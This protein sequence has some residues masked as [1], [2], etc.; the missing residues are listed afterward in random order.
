LNIVLD[1]P[2]NMRMFCESFGNKAK[3]TWNCVV[4]DTTGEYTLHSRTPF[5]K[6]LWNLRFSLGYGPIHKMTT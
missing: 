2:A 6:H 5:A 1:S 4:P 3:M